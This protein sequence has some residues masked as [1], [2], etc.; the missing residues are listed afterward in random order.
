MRQGVDKSVAKDCSA[1]PK[2]RIDRGEAGPN[3]VHVVDLAS[4]VG[5]E[6]RRAPSAR[7]VS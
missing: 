7:V 2:G 4:T 1:S 3:R 6:G 5:V